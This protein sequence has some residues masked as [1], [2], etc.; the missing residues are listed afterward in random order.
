MVLVSERKPLSLVVSNYRYSVLIIR[1]SRIGR[2][3][4]KERERNRGRQ[5]DR[6]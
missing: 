6:I 4:E 3:K 2:E 5:D 1:E